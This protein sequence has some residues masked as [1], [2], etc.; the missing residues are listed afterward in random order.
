MARA[1]PRTCAALVPSLVGGN[2][3]DQA[4][5][6]A[7]SSSGPHRSGRAREP[8]RSSGRARGTCAL[9]VHWRAAA[10]APAWRVA[11]ATGMRCR[12]S[13]RPLIAP[14]R[15]VI[16]DDESAPCRLLTVGQRQLII[17]HGRD[18]TAQMPV[19]LMIP[20]NLTL[21]KVSMPKKKITDEA[22]RCVQSTRT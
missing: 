17:L 12:P 22:S 21:P 16:D 13:R 10:A 4:A 2:S 3:V 20:G 6:M 15:N 1:T 9:G 7:M 14:F 5:R 11:V 18:C 19:P 8:S